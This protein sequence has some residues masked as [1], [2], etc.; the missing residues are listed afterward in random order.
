MGV[1]RSVGASLVMLES[2]KEIGLP[3]LAPP[4]GRRGLTRLFFQRRDRREGRLREDPEPIDG[5]CADIG[6]RAGGR[7]R[8]AHGRCQDNRIKLTGRKRRDD[9]L[10][11][12]WFGPL[13]QDPRE[14]ILGLVGPASMGTTS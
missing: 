11:G 3:G 13:G 12:Q 9:T 6:C 10:A 14:T 4:G 2:P 8:G 7:P 1:E 5:A